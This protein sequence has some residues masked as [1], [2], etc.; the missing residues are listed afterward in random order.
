MWFIVAFGIRDAFIS[1]IQLLMPVVRPM[2]FWGDLIYNPIHGLV[3]ALY[4]PLLAYGVLRHQLLEIDLKLRFAL[5]QGA[6]GAMIAG[7][8]LVV[9][10]ALESI[11]PVEG[12]VTAIV[13]AVVIA[14]ILRPA[15]KVAERFAN[16]LMPGVTPTRGYLH[17]RRLNVFRSA[18]EGAIADGE[19][20]QNEEA[21]LSRLRV[22]LEITKDE[23]QTLRRSVLQSAGSRRSEAWPLD[24]AEAQSEPG[25]P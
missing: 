20:T 9:S 2:P 7:T 19:I 17:E 24:T 21:I 23:E 11:V 22:Q 25:A 16:Q 1:M 4:V 13:L 12:V 3:Y 5:T 8:F 15:Q 18:L 14:V 10:E 6:V